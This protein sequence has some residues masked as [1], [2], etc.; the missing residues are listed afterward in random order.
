M[1]KKYIKKK[2]S[3]V[4]LHIPKYL[5]FK[6][7]FKILVPNNSVKRTNLTMLK[8]GNIGL[9]ALQSSY[10]TLTHIEIIRKFLR[11]ATKNKISTLKTTNLW[12]KLFTDRILTEKPNQSR[13]GRGKGLS[14]IWYTK[15][16]KNQLL[17]EIRDT[18]NIHKSIRLLK[19]IIKKL[20]ILT[21]IIC[22]R[23]TKYFDESLK[24]N[25][26]IYVI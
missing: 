26:L 3:R 21:G 15:V 17:I 14:S 8:Y 11:P 13:I 9:Y 18:V 1:I 4:K 22:K 6:R 12:I 7:Y 19:F 20:P 23:E 2:K 16:F 5:K 24:K 10:L 25:K